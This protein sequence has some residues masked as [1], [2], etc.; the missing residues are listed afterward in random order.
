MIITSLTSHN[1]HCEN[2]LS[3]VTEYLKK[4]LIFTHF[5]TGNAPFGYKTQ[6]F[7]CRI[8]IADSV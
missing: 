4:V 3:I 2:V 1:E 6:V 5:I 8:Y 7:Y